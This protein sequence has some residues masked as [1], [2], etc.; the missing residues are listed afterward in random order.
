MGGTCLR[1]N[2]LDEGI[3]N[4]KND[5]SILMTMIRIMTM[6]MMTTYLIFVTDDTDGVRVNFFGRCKFLK[7]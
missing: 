2:M 5:H 1:P 6:V 3:D 4:K 7:I